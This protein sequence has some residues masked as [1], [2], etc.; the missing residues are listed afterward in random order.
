MTVAKTTTKK[1][2]TAKKAPSERTK[3]KLCL[4]CLQERYQ[5]DHFYASPDKNLNADGRIPYCKECVA[6]QIDFTQVD[7]LIDTLRR[8]DRPFIKKDYVDALSFE[9]PFGEY[10]KRLGMR[11]NIE[12]NYSHSEFDGDLSHHKDKTIEDVKAEL[13]GNKEIKFEITPELYMKWGTGYEDEEIYHLEEFFN[14]MKASNRIETPQHIESLKL[15]AKINLKQNQALDNNDT[16]AFSK[17]NQQYNKTLQDAKLRP[18]DTQGSSSEAGIVSFSQIY[19]KVEEYGFI[20]K[21]QVE[22]TQDIVDGTILHVENY[23]R[24][25]LNMQVVSEP[26][27]ETPKVEDYNNE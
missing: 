25:F 20:P 27:G 8:I 3:K 16:T 14:R 13:N 23:T 12:K 4:S 17:L 11:H 15:L 5:I 19:E 18:I 1:K 9:N 26:T 6:K 22:A 7:T 21:H 24:R 10:M 2:A